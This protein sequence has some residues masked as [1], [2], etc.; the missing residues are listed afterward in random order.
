MKYALS[1]LALLLP[2]IAMAQPKQV[3][4]TCGGTTI[5]QVGDTI[6]GTANPVGQEC[7]SASV[8]ASI[9]GFAPATTGTP[10]SVTTGGV[11]GTLPAGTVVV[12]SN[13]GATNGA[14]CKLGASA[15]TSARCSS[16]S[17]SLRTPFTAVCS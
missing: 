16:N 6:N 14:Y 13:V 15:T 11:T 9:S 2:S 1:L 7:V 4:T 10:I 3:V 5:A 12:V 17:F 8:S